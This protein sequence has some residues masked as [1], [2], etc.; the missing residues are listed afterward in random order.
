MEQDTYSISVVAEHFN[1]DNKTVLRCCKKYGLK[2]IKLSVRTFR[3]TREDFDYIKRNGFIYYNDK[4]R[5][6][7][8]WM[9]DQTTLPGI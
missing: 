4:I 2:V 3:I 8:A 7:D 5:G 9:K 6:K 1:V